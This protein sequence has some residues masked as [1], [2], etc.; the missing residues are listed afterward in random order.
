[1]GTRPEVIKLFPVINIFKKKK[2]FFKT[3]IAISGQHREIV[4][5]LLN[6]FRIEVNYDFN[7]IK[8][9]QSLFDITING[10][11]GMSKILN[12]SNPDLVFVQ[13]D[14]TSAFIGALSSFYKKIY[15]AHIE[16]G[17]R[18]YDKYSPF[19]EEKN[20]VLISHLSD[21]HFTT[22]IEAKKNLLKE[23]IKKNI[24]VVG[25]T[26]ID[27]LQYIITYFENN[28]KLRNE[29]SN[30]F[31]NVDFSK[32]II[33][34]TSHRRENFGDNLLNICVALKELARKIPDIEILFP[35]H[36]N[37]NVLKPVKSLLNKI[38]NIHLYPPLFY[39]YFIWLLQR[40]FLI[41][42]DSG[43][44]QEEASYLGKPLLILR[45]N[46][47]RYEIIKNRN[48]KLI[49]TDTKRIIKEVEK[50]IYNKNE[51]KKMLGKVKCYGNGNASEK[52]YK[53]IKEFFYGKEN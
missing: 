8:E 1:M 51:Y 14:T 46:T 19:P 35:V 5:D 25:N 27:S 44:I 32:K 37:P 13:G 40:T 33:L 18:T 16:A 29:I 43:G 12:K 49:G 31:K 48:G 26:V 47:E 23:N 11:R 4:D 6:F 42:T 34:I 20:R 38:K 2:K 3:E 53:I 9:N 24:W 52:I 22:T 10:L 15:I 17:L 39:P 28:L 30:Y 21:F 7:L 36:P 45:N 41:L 50:L